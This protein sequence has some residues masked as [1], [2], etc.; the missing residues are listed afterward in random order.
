MGTNYHNIVIN[1]N[2]SRKFH[3]PLMIEEIGKILLSV[4]K[5]TFSKIVENSHTKNKTILLLFIHVSW[6][7]NNQI[8]L[9]K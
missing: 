4:S 9:H 6:V 3:K 1:V 7:V 8:I 2:L 5:E